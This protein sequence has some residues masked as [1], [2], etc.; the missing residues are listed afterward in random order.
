MR[1]FAFAAALVV[2]FTLSARAEDKKPTDDEIKKL[3]PGKWS[4][5]EDMMGVK[6]VASST[7]KKDGTFEGEA[8]IDAKGKEIKIKVSGSWEVKD[9]KLIETIKKSDSPF[10]KEGKMSTDTILA[11]D[12]KSYKFKSESGREVTVKRVKE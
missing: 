11:I 6:V 4:Y 12:E 2:A 8:N 3:L 7:F 1:P 5:E 10:A 9:G